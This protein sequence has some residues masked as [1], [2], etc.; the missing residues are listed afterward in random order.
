ML[1]R[2]YLFALLL[3]PLPSS[4]SVIDVIGK[5]I[6]RKNDHNEIDHHRSLSSLIFDND[7]C[8]RCICAASSGCQINSRCR[9]I[10]PDKYLCGPFRLSRS[11]WKM[12][13]NSSP[14][15]YQWLD[16][17]FNFEQCAHDLHCSIRTI[18]NFMRKFFFGKCPQLSEQLLLFNGNNRSIF[19]QCTRISMIHYQA[20]YGSE[21]VDQHSSSPISWDNCNMNLTYG[22]NRLIVQQIEWLEKNLPAT[23]SDNYYWHNF[24]WCSELYLL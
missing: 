22:D 5:E 17:P 18:K 4:S 1:N 15:H 2:I 6:Y 9:I 8:L 11:Y 24:F 12:A 13:N 21:D 10:E 14:N 23:R 7:D 20:I 3:L 19:D 16:Y